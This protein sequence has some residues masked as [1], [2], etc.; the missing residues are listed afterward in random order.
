MLLNHTVQTQIIE[1]FRVRQ[2]RGLFDLPELKTASEEFSVEL[3]DMHEDWQIGVIVGPS[4]S[5]KSTVA[6]AAYGENVITQRNWPTDRAVIDALPPGPIKRVTGML[7]AVGFA[8]PPS[9]LKPYHVLSTGEQFRCDLAA[10]LLSDHSLIVFDE[11]TSVVDRTV[12]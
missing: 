1:S 3:P 5:G 10:A 11:F 4:G 7:S 8:S 6:R 9:W 12:A 2:T